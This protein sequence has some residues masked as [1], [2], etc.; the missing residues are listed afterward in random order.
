MFEVKKKFFLKRFKKKKGSSQSVSEAISKQ[1]IRP[2]KLVPSG[3]SRVRERWR[4]TEPRRPREGG[5]FP[6][7]QAH[8]EFNLQKQIGAGVFV[9]A[10]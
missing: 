3:G 9:I 6:M 5:R 1:T 4:P 10:L 2:V 8:P 7:K